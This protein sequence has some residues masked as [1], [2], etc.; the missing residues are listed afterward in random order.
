MSGKLAKTF[1][2]LARII[3]VGLMVFLPL[4]FL[5][6]MSDYEGFN[7]DWQVPG[8]FLL[9]FLLLFINLIALCNPPDFKDSWLGLSIKRRRLEQQAKIKDLENHLKDKQGDKE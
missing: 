8:L 7:M 5:N 9:A 4:L 1:T 2:N 3:T 6:V